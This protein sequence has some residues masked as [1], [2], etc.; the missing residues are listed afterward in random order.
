MTGHLLYD[1]YAWLVFIV[2]LSYIM[3]C[4][5]CARR[6]CCVEKPNKASAIVSQAL[7]SLFPLHL[8]N[9]SSLEKNIEIDRAKTS[10]CTS[11]EKFSRLE[12][13]KVSLKANRFC[14]YD[15]KSRQKS[16][17]V[18]VSG[19]FSQDCSQNRSQKS[20]PGGLMI[21]KVSVCDSGGRKKYTDY[22]IQ[23]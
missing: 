23:K 12:P 13:S 15:Y 7:L 10:T 17:V 22:L 1:R 8:S 3:G 5:V 19:K 11:W 18:G 20:R 9:L 2:C 16:F 14:F 6:T 4:A 21:L